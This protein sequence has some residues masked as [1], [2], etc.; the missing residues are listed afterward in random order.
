MQ[1]VQERRQHFSKDANPH[2]LKSA[3]NAG[4]SIQ[5]ASPMTGRSEPCCS[6]TLARLPFGINAIDPQGGRTSYERGPSCL[7]SRGG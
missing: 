1:A 2:K 7:N 5:L 3:R 4:V 6:G